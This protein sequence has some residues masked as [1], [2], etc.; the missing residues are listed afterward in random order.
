MPTPLWFYLVPSGVWL[1]LSSSAFSVFV[2][3]LGS[4]FAFI[5]GMRGLHLTNVASK[6][7][8][9]A[10]VIAVVGMILG[11]TELIYVLDIVLSIP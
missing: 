1:L 3:G 5:Y 8:L 2:L 4:A 6:M 11:V 7:S 10:S 9:C